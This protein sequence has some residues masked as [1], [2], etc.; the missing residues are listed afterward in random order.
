MAVR[1]VAA[2]SGVSCCPGGFRPGRGMRDGSVCR[3]AKVGSPRRAVPGAGGSGMTASETVSGDAAGDAAGRGMVSPP[4]AALPGLSPMGLVWLAV[5]LAGAGL[6]FWDG[7]I[8]LGAA[9]ST[10][11]YSHGPLI[12]LLSFWMYLR[13]MRAVPPVAGPVTDRGPGLAITLF[14]L[15]IGLAGHIV[16]IPDI[17]TYGFILWV[18]GL[19]L[20]TYGW[21]RGILFWPSVLHLVYMLP[22]PNFLY[23]P[24]SIE[25]QLISSEIGVWVI[26]SLGIPVFLDGN[27]IDL[28]AWKLQVAEACS[29]LRYLFPILSFSY[30]TALLYRGPVWH[31]IVLLVAAAPIT[32]LMNSF[33]IGMIGVLVNSYG[34]EHAEGFLHAFEGW[35]IFAACVAVLMLLAVGLQRLTRDPK[36]LSEALDLDFAG[37]DRQL[38]RVRGIVPA[39]SLAVAGIAALGLGLAMHL[40]PPRETAAV[41][42]EP[43]VLFPRT[44]ADWSGQTVRL[45]P[46]VEGVLAADDYLSARYTGPG[47]AVDLFVAWYARQAGGAGIH[48]PEVCLPTGGWEVSD[49]RQE[50]V[51]VPATGPGAVPGRTIAVPVNRAVIQK[52]LERQLV[53]YWFEG[54]GRRETSDYLAKLAVVWDAAADGRSDGALVRLVT[55]IGPGED[56]DAAAARL[57]RFLAEALPDLPR[58]VPE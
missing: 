18:G 12:P 45:D 47:G 54:R 21:R 33:R 32:V 52:G 10:P 50:V 7:L 31:K 9:W 58:F 20:T 51:A 22:L 36:P 43:L 2:R 27:V 14:A 49:W 28:G 34:I 42:R 57:T 15:S 19:L 53:W 25:L 39:R 17:I 16:Q 29:G 13:E 6:V 11:E 8:S 24:L 48:S 44:V 1:R 41:P 23:W 4:G 37:L 5:A 38:A 40:T 55:P 26:R 46:E 35:I 56:E 30:I 3:T